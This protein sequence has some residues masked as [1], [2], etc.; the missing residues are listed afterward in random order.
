LAQRRG[1]LRGGPRSSTASGTSSSISPGPR[2]PRP[3]SSPR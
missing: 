1:T 2:R 3:A